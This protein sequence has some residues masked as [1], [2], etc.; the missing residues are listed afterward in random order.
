MTGERPIGEDDLQAYVDGRLAPEIR[1]NVEAYLRAN[2]GR[3]AQVEADRELRASLRE[4]LAFKAQEP[5]PARLRIANIWGGR[6]HGG[7]R[8]LRAVAVAMAWL[9]VGG[10]AGWTAN[11]WIA[12]P[13]SA[14]VRAPSGAATLDGMTAHR[15]FVV[16]VAHPVEVPASQEAHLVQW[17]SR[18][19]GAPLS[20]PDLSAQGF[21]LMG[22]RLLPAGEQPAAQFMYEDDKGTRLTV[23]VR[24]EGAGERTAF[25]FEAQGEVS[26]FSW[27]D[28]GLSYVV[29]AK[30]D[31]ARLLDVAEAVY[32]QLDRQDAAR[33]KKL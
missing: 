30:V 16:E 13:R 10:A 8:W 33:A 26:A 32:Q 2:P 23:Y 15:T 25:R 22:G 14:S 12:G 27:V 5:I 7:H 9:A 24:P 1:E 31:R 20:A 3:T 4:R 17:L 18:R 29:V 11:N 21:R 19:L 28:R 6:R